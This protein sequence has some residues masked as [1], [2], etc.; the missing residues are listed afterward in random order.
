[1]NESRG[2]V[3]PAAAV[4]GA[5]V[6]VLAVVLGVG[7][8]LTH[9]LEPTVDP[10]DDDVARWFAGERTGDLDRVA[11]VGTFLGETVVGSAVAG[12]VGLVVSVWRRSVRPA[13]CMALL[14]AGI[15]G[16]YAIVTALVTRDRPPVR[17]LDPGLVPDHS[18]PSGHVATA[19][20]AYAGSAVLL[21][22][23]T[24]RARPW[25][26]LLL[27]LPVLVLLARLYQGAHHVTDVLTSVVYTTTWLAV[28][29]R[30][31]LLRGPSGTMER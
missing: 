18:F 19:V 2:W 16:L 23:A 6:L 7:W 14:L 26:L 27:V 9:P 8:L 30:A 5:W 10:F 4:V 1:V 15:G 11:D 28:L 21:W 12:L 31:V 29:A 24:P 22:W 13:V 20:A 17:I 25:A 3:R